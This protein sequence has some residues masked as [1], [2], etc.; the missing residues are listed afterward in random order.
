MSK[1]YANFI[2]HDSSIDEGGTTDWSC[3]EN[4]AVRAEEKDAHVNQYKETH[5]RK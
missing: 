3:E 4:K 2:C 5:T 1:H